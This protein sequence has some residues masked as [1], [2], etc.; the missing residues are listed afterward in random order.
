[1]KEEIE[2]ELMPGD[3]LELLGRAKK[4]GEPIPDTYIA[5]EAPEPFYYRVEDI[6][7]PDVLELIEADKKKHGPDWEG[8]WGED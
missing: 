3:E 5:P 2:G 7:S 8:D 1:M 6:V 4:R